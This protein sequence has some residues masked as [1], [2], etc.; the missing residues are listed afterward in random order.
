MAR[1]PI[2]PVPRRVWLGL[3]L[4]RL[5]HWRIAAIHQPVSAPRRDG[6]RMMI[7]IFL[8]TGLALLEAGGFLAIYAILFVYFFP[9][10][11]LRS[12]LKRH[13]G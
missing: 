2:R 9:W 3:S 8:L 5:R 1:P 4:H 10:R 12:A 11:M 6:F 13:S 7:L